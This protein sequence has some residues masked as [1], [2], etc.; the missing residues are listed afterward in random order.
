MRAAAAA[1]MRSCSRMSSSVAS[2]CMAASWRPRF[3]ALLGPFRAAF[4]SFMRP[5]AAR[6]RARY[7]TREPQVAQRSSL[8]AM[9][10][11]Q[12][13]QGRRR[14]SLNFP[15]TETKRAPQ[16]QTVAARWFSAPQALHFLPRAGLAAF[17]FCGGGAAA[18]SGSA[19]GSP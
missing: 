12:S 4:F 6:S 19:P 16:A 2:T 1:N 7:S 9:A 18:R 11:S 8:A 15:F 5:R 3:V 10:A 13:A 17:F 14:S